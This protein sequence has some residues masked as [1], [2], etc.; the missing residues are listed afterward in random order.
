MRTCS[1]PAPSHGG[2]DCGGENN[3]TRSCIVRQCAG[4]RDLKLHLDAYT[5][6]DIHNAIVL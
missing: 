5:C 1:A 3:E 2:L 6:A 4:R